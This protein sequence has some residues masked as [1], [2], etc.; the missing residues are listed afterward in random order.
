MRGHMCGEFNR[1]HVFIPLIELLSE[2]R[3]TAGR[4]YTALGSDSTV[5]ASGTATTGSTE[6]TSDS[7]SVVNA[8]CSVI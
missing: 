8:G 5:A 1:N 7:A 2:A 4:G 6:G 3:Q